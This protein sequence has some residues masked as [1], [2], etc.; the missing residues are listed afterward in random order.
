MYPC[1]VKVNSPSKKYLLR[2]LTACS[3]T[4]RCQTQSRCSV[5]GRE[6]LRR[7][8]W[9]HRLESLRGNG[10]QYVEAETSSGFAQVYA[11][12]RE[13]SDVLRLRWVGPDGD[14]QTRH[15]RHC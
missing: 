5:D 6:A 8:H 14:S 11:Q 4:Q 10:C 13:G 7:C 2:W 3:P 1:M 9:S 12:V 15:S